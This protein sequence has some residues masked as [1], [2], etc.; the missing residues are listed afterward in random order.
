MTS[1]AVIPRDGWP[2]FGRDRLVVIKKGFGKGSVPSKRIAESPSRSSTSAEWSCRTA[3]LAGRHQLT[4][5]FTV[6][7]WPQLVSWIEP[8][9]SYSP[10]DKSVGVSGATVHW[11]LRA[12]LFDT[13]AWMPSQ[14]RTCSTGGAALSAG[15]HRVSAQAG[16]ASHV[17]SGRP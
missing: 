16:V 3:P 9:T 11:L 8:A 1:T 4:S 17:L 5:R 6:Y 2:R 12:T 14:L 10:S 7:G 15:K 13:N